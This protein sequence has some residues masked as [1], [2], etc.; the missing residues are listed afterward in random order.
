VSESDYRLNQKA[1]VSIA[2]QISQLTQ[3]NILTE[4]DWKH[5]R[6]LFD[7]VYPGFLVRLKE[8]LGDLTPAE[9]RILVLAK[10]QIPQKEMGDMLGISYNSIRTSRYRLRKKLNLPE[11]GSLE[12]LVALI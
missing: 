7:V 12:E 5:F 3:L 11:E 8:K 6:K 1:L 4:E 2:L 9:I 10:L